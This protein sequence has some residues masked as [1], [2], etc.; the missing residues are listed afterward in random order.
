[1]DQA[2][3]RLR[4]IRVL[5]VEDTW[6]VAHAVQSLLA[7]MGMVVVGPVANISDAERL[8]SDQV[9]QLA[10]VDVNLKEESAV[11]LINTLTESGVSVVVISGL[12]VHVSA[13]V[14]I[15]ASLQKP[16]SG[17]ELLETLCNVLASRIPTGD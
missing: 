9:L 14:S 3:A 5:I 13:S 17:P 16:F 6:A 10:V 1:M 12:P 7:E 4:G 8:L 2:V 15:A 11:G